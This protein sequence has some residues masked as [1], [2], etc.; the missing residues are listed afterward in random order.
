MDPNQLVEVRT[1]LQESYRVDRE[2]GSGGMATVYLAHDLKHDR[3]VAIKVIRPDLAPIFGPDR[4]LREISIAAK[5]NHPTIL[6]LYESG[7]AG[8]HLYYVMPYIAGE[9]LR[10]RLARKKQL[11]I[12]E[13]IR[14]TRQVA[15][16]WE[17]AHSRGVIHRDI[18]PANILLS[19]GSRWSAIS[20]LPWPSSRPP[21]RRRSARLGSCSARDIPGTPCSRCQRMV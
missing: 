13:A 5:L 15:A 19:G 17:Y 7:D 2:L 3:P 16:G 4:F 1:A 10:D 14:I 9:T 20:V 11:P 6:A 18:K 8:G 21:R 12:D